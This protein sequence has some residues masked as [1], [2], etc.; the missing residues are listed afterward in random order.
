MEKIGENILSRQARIPSF[1]EVKQKEKIVQDLDESSLDAID[2]HIIQIASSRIKGQKD[3]RTLT[4]IKSKTA[5]PIR[6]FALLAFF[7]PSGLIFSLL[8]HG[9]I[10]N[11]LLYN[12]LIMSYII[13]LTVTAFLVPYY[14]YHVIRV[15]KMRKYQNGLER[16]L[17]MRIKVKFSIIFRFINNILKYITPLLSYLAFG[18][19]YYFSIP[20]EF[21]LFVMFVD[22]VYYECFLLINGMKGKISTVPRRIFTSISVTGLLTCYIILFFNDLLEFMFFI[23]PTILVVSTL[24]YK[25]GLLEK[26]FYKK[27]TDG[28]KKINIYNFA[29]HIKKD[30]KKKTTPIEDLNSFREVKEG[31]SPQKRLFRIRSISKFLEAERIVFVRKKEVKE[32]FNIYFKR[33]SGRKF[34]KTEHELLYRIGRRSHDKIKEEAKEGLKWYKHN[35]KVREI[36]KY[37]LWLEKKQIARVKHDEAVIIRLIYE[38]YKISREIRP[39]DKL[40][41]KMMRDRNSNDIPEKLSIDLLSALI[42]EKKKLIRLLKQSY[43]EYSYISQLGIKEYMFLYNLGPSETIK[44]KTEEYKK[45]A[46]YNLYKKADEFFKGIIN[47]GD[48][49]LSISSAEKKTREIL[50]TIIYDN[51]AID[52]DK[53]IPDFLYINHSQTEVINVKCEFEIKTAF[54]VLAQNRKKIKEII[55]QNLWLYKLEEKEYPKKQKSDLSAESKVGSNLRTNIQFKKN[56]DLIKGIL[57]IFTIIA[58]IFGLIIPG[59]IDS[60]PVTVGRNDNVLI[61]YKIWKTDKFGNYNPLNPE[62]DEKIWISMIPITE[63]SSSGLILGLYNNLMEKELY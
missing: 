35:F 43:T 52:F 49:T 62:F 41:L 45:Q 48:K 15:L 47:N 19:W 54:M 30:Q 34:T 46:V 4:R 56:R 18:L 23:I 16:N 13:I 26:L 21:F 50:Y 32:I 5:I 6:Y 10:F 36:R 42:T 24:V 17:Y 25:A 51:I 37:R 7:F 3:F 9:W 22:F 63:N 58:V 57:V 55:E 27:K 11:P 39:H 12:L 38:Q 33:I 59:L 44:E 14:Y 28:I 20:M 8:I 61:D 29:V 60:R 40:Y 2:E 53:D 1:V 31:N